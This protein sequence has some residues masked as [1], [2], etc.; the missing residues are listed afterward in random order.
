MQEVNK[1]ED[2]Q[3]TDIL[4]MMQRLQSEIESLKT[5]NKK[6]KKT[7]AKPKETEKKDDP[8]RLVVIIHTDDLADNLFTILK[9]DSEYRF[10]KFGDRHRVRLIEAEKIVSNHQTYFNRG[11][12]AFEDD[13]MYDYFSSIKKPNMITVAEWKN[14]SNMPI[15]ELKK[16][17]ERVCPLHKEAILRH[18]YLEFNNGNPAYKDYAKVSILNNVSNGL[19]DRMLKDLTIDRIL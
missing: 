15:E 7:P 2:T 4:N 14:L 3:L 10:C 8:N 6:L 13:E 11:M 18:W 19:F 5:E 17:F 16:L 12:I 9:G 1:P